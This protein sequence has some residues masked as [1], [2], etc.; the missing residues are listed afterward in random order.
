MLADC[1]WRDGAR[2]GDEGSD[3]RKRE[4]EMKGG[5]ERKQEVEM[6]GITKG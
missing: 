6:N 4:K 1:L 5:M 3:G 2:R